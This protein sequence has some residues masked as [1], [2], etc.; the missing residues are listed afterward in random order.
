MDIRITPSNLSGNIEAVS[1]KSYAHRL[2]L[3][4][5]LSNA[6]S[7]LYIKNCSADLSATIEVL[8]SLGAK[9]SSSSNLYKITPIN[10]DLLPEKITIDVHDSGAT[11]RFMLPIISALL[12]QTTYACDSKLAT[13]QFSDLLYSL[14]GIGF[15]AEKLPF[16][17]KG[18]LNCGEYYIAKGINS[19]FVSGL[20]FAL[21]LLKEDSK[22]IFMQKTSTLNTDIT[23]Q[24]LSLFGIKIDKTEQ[25]YLVYGNQ[26]YSAI[27]STVVEGDYFLSA[28]WYLAN[29]LG[30]DISIKNLN[31]NSMQ[32]EKDFFAEIDS[33]FAKPNKTIKVIDLDRLPLLSVGACFVKGQTIL[34]LP[35]LITAKEVAKINVLVNAISK[36]GGGIRFTENK[37]IVN[38]N[39]LVGDC[40]VDCFGDFKLAMAITIGGCYCKRSIKILDCQCVNKGY[41]GFFNDLNSLGGKANAE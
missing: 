4:C 14:K 13:K 30:G 40:I 1:S 20:M 38:G 39:S 16:T 2:V 27:P 33:L 19:Q 23:M 32:I 18:R 36:M 11:L 29:K 9:I 31:V 28:Y 41:S 8:K 5:A 22:I 3:A 37:I 21:P 34:E 17:T 7:E 35:Q 26:K 12:S 24:V 10:F 25:G 6:S 15:S